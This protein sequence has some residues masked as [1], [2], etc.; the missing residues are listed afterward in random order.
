[1]TQH[2]LAD[3]SGVSRSSVAAIEGGKYR[4]ARSSTLAA[5]A[6][7]LRQPTSALFQDK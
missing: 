6:R 7:A 2:E 3:V 4:S 1:M 5:L